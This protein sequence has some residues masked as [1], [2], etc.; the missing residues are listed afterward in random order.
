[1]SSIEEV[2]Y[3]LRQDSPLYYDVYYSTGGVSNIG[4]GYDVWVRHW[5]DEIAPK[6]NKAFYLLID[7][8]K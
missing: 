6:L 8:N 4:G 2:H 1:M 3:K 5:I 7:R